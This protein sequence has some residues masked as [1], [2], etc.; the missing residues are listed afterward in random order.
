M[1]SLFV[2]FGGLSSHSRIFHLY[3]DV[4]TGEDLCS[5]LM[6][7]EQWGFFS[8]PHWLWHRASVY[9]GHVRGPVTLTPIADRLAVEL[10][11]PVFTTYVCRR[12]DSNTQP[13]A[14]EASTLTHCATAAISS[15]CTPTNNISKTCIGA[16]ITYI[17][18][19]RVISIDRR[20]NI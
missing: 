20:S 10:S 12:W 17:Y 7:I 14:C 5:A 13:S 6:A 15:W 2:C 3:G 18:V 4:T 1:V 9:N 19:I 11:L 16:K 8:V